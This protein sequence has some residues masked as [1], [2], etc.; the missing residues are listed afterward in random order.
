MAELRIKKLG[1]GPYDTNCYVVSTHPGREA[2]LIDT[3]AD[4]Q[5]V[6]A[7]LRGLAVRFILITHGHS[8]HLGAFTELRQA[9]AVPVGAHPL[10]APS[11]PSPPDWLLE[12]GQELRLGSLPIRVI[13]TPGHTAGSLCFLVGQHLFSGDTLFPNGP[14]K[15]ATPQ[16][17]EAVLDSLSREIF[18]LPDETAVHPGHGPDTVLG[19]ERG[20]FAAF[21]S[22]PRR[23]GLCGDVVWVPG[24]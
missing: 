22:R 3:P 11:L 23:P 14:G 4:P 17:F 10:E 19:K 6:L 1:L 20:L 15:T 21:K 12:H 2:L 9:L 16:A 7:A 24:S 13:H 8:D 18:P 5:R